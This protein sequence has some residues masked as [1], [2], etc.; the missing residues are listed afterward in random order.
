MP[1]RKSPKVEQARTRRGFGRLRQ[2]P[3]GRWQ[4]TYAH[5]GAVHKAATTFP[6]KDAAVA[7]LTAESDLIELDRRNLGV[8]S[9]PADRDAKTR[10]AQLTLRA[11]AETW[12]E[13][14]N[15]SPR[16]RE[17]YR[18]H[19]TDNIYPALGETVLTEITPEDVRAWF[20]G[21]GTTHE[22]RNARAYGVLTAVLNTAVDDGLI[23]RSPAR[24][25][26]AS[27]VKRTKR[28]VVLLEPAELA[29]LAEKMPEELRLTVLLTGWC[30]LRR[31]ELFAL[32]REDVAEDGSTLRIDK[33]ITRREQKDIC[34]PPKTRESNRTVT[35]PTHLRPLLL[36]HL[37]QRVGDG[38]KALL[39]PDPTTG[40]FYPEGRFRVPFF[41]ARAAIGKPDLHLHDLRHFGGVMAAVAGA[42][43]KEVMDRLGHTTSAA[44][45]RYQHVA[46][47]RA[48]AIADRLSALAAQ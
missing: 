42:T 41:A 2:L 24:I 43:T 19:L 7:W 14:R 33:A 25:K 5:R 13:H 31:G 23:D 46:A 1:P 37:D 32:T 28:S 21:L 12:L 4:A 9:S 15:I 11:Y 27:S 44:A 20:A 45:M 3:S 39:F 30:G 26:G 29:A 16:T 47:G 6:T 8:W 34:G 18:Y 38:R 36:D 10:A 40:G 17:N 35:V 48:D 22:T